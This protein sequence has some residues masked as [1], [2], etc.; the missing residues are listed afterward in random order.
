MRSA[1]FGMRND[2]GEPGAVMGRWQL[3]EDSWQMADCSWQKARAGS[4]GGSLATGQLG[5]WGSRTESREARAVEGSW[6]KPP[7]V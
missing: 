4:R 5:N 6:P 7:L 1:E 3:T 2:Y